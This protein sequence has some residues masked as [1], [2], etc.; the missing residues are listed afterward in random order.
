[1]TSIARITLYVQPRASRTELSGRHG[2]DVKIRLK[3][4]P[5]DDVANEELIAF[6]AQ[7]LGIPRRQVRLVAGARSR[8]KTLEVID[9]PSDALATL[10]GIGDE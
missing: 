9:A 2:A 10:C 1:M 7:R 5:V 4:P 8:R 6:V 3:S